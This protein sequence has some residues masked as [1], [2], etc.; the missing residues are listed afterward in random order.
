CSTTGSGATPPWAT[1]AQW[2]TSGGPQ[3][4][5]WQRSQPVHRT[6]AGPEVASRLRRRRPPSP[7]RRPGPRPG[8]PVHGDVQ[9][10]ARPRR[11]RAK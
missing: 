3:P 9:D 6:G 1:S 11:N 2:N 7:T 5:G 8:R 10:A 4:R